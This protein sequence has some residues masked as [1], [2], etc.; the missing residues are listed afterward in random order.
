MTRPPT[1]VTVALAALVP[2]CTP[3]AD[4]AAVA[5]WTPAF[6]PVALAI[7][8]GSSEPQVSALSNG[9]IVSW[10]EGQQDPV[11]VRFA[12]RTADGWSAPRALVSGSGWFRSYADMPAVVRLS[13][14]TLVASWLPATDP[15]IEAYDLALAY[16]TDDG[17]TWSEPFS[18][19]HDGTTT[20]HGFASFIEPPEGG[21]GLVW[22][23]GRQQELDLESPDGGAMSLRYAT[24]DTNW[25]QTADMLV[26]D[27]VCEC[28]PT[29]T[30]LTSDGVV[31]AFRDRSG[32]EVRDIAVSRLVDGRWTA[33][34]P[35]HSDGW[36]IEACPVNGPAMSTRGDRVAVT[37]FT[38]A[39]GAGHAF[40]AFSEDGGR[41]FDDPIQ[42]DDS[43]TLGRTGV[44]LLP[45]GSAV[46]SWLE[47]VNNRSQLRVGR[48]LPTGERLPPVLVSG[49]GAERPSGYPRLAVG[50]GQLVA[51]WTETVP[52]AE[53]G[54][55]GIP[56]ITV[57]V[58]E[59]AL[60]AF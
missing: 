27:R 2:G 22:L 20:Q 12:E 14:S 15:F 13:N 7:P 48:V 53:G 49:E 46:A 52:P 43:G 41:T 10:V 55:D 40:L 19:H 60:P 16:S 4:P 6:A 50:G 37:W 38:V 31:T 54:S 3:S 44:V 59:A 36:V 29:A 11:T 34:A 8:N 5:A 56:Q 32:D 26:D 24:F 45:D 33:A 23:D 21:L 47:Y 35:I 51:A 1:L 42:L 25:V 17:E 39:D 57:R 28:C 30:G 18:P 58:A 9:V